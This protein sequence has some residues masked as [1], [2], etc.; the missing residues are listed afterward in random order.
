M[1][2]TALYPAII[3]SGIIWGPLVLQAQTDSTLAEKQL[4]KVNQQVLE[5]LEKSGADVEEARQ[6]LQSLQ[7]SLETLPEVPADGKLQFGLYLEDLDFQE[8]YE[9]HYPYNYGVLVS[10]VVTGG[11]ADRAGIVKGDIIMEFDGE[12]VRY[13]DHLISLR[14]T[15]SLGDTVTLT[16]FRNENIIKRTLTF[17]PP[18][19]KGYEEHAG[20]KVGKKRLSPGYGG[21]GPMLVLT[22][23]KFPEISRMLTN[24]GFNPNLD[25]VAFVGGFGM[26]NVGKGLFIGGGGAGYSSSQQIPKDNGNGYKRYQL[27]SGFGGVMVH[28]KRA[29]FSKKFVLDAGLLLGGG[30]TKVTVSST[31]GDFS[32]NSQIEN[33]IQSESFS[34]EKNYLVVQP[35]LGALVRVTDWFGL[36]GSVGYLATFPQGSDWKESNFDFVVKDGRPD[37]FNDVTYTLGIWF[38]Y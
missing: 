7:V 12:K 22:N 23:F 27:D 25:L 8:A 19:P 36:N 2:K 38:G 20:G 16:I 10:G 1:K 14:D 18:A 29:L 30:S 24:N 4:K 5:E 31:D 28:K 32:W 6:Q 33:N 35:S 13:E 9:R 3:L 21:G 11:N 37:V 15:K 26:G 17:N 34:Y